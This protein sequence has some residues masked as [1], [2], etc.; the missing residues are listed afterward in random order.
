MLPNVAIYKLPIDT[1]VNKSIMKIEREAD[2]HN[3][4]I[5]DYSDYYQIIKPL[6][7]KGKPRAIKGQYLS[8]ALYCPI[9]GLEGC[10]KRN[11]SV[12]DYDEEQRAMGVVNY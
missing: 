8:E 4:Q 11:H 7:G 9:C 1:T 12:Y 2:M 3:V 10:I 5:A 6:Q